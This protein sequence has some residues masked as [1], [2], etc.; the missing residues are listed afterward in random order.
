[1]SVF[2]DFAYAKES[3][4]KC[5]NLLIYKEK[6]DCLIFGHFSEGLDFQGFAAN[7]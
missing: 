3:L 6:K 5:K 2:V 1:V 7:A 4:D